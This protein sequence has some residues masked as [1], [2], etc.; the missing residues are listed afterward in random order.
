MTKAP[1]QVRH[2]YVHV[3]FCRARCAYCDFASEPVGPH[4]RAGRVAAYLER[5]RAELRE[6]SGAGA[7]SGVA[8]GAGGSCVET[9][10][11]GGG[12]P[13]VVPRELLLP[14]V[15][16]LAAL[17][18]GVEAPEFTIEAN[19]GTIAAGLLA[20]L[21]ECGVTR[22]SLGVQSFAPRL[23]AALGR[24]TT[25]SEIEAALHALRAAGAATG[26]R[27]L[28][29]W[30]LDLVFGIPGQ[31]WAEAAADIDTAMAAG[32]THISLYDLTYTTAYAARVARTAG[33]GARDA[34]GAFAEEYLPAAAARLAAGGY[35]RYE[36]SNF[37][38]PGRECRHNLGYWRGEDYL[39]IGASAV[40]TIGLERRTNPATVTAYLAGDAPAVEALTPHTRLWEKAMLGLRTAEGV[41]EAEV[42]PV[43]DGAALDRLLARDCVE[44]ACGRLRL[45]PGFL[46]VSNTVISTLLAPPEE[47]D[48]ML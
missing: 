15:A 11:L 46:D 8:S 10:Y 44:R 42:L 33:A 23:R 1:V 37:A 14:L 32:P 4:L 6:S 45:N 30:N 17:Q 47:S 16:D 31:T 22:V 12:T 3:P 2:L 7:Q 41:V 18:A 13:T 43:V 48:S 25:Q 19:P 21:G 5:L 35:R 38:L 28:R 29:G 39:G 26:G 9:I 27:R 40:S 24:R 36:V 34:A 20:E